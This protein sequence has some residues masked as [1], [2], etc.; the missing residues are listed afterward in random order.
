MKLFIYIRHLNLISNMLNY[1]TILYIFS[2]TLYKYI[3][4]YRY[5]FINKIFAIISDEMFF[6]YAHFFIYIYI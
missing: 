5:A 4:L 3:V 6:D 2:H 1:Y